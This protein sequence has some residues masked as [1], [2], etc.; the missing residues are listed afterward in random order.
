MTARLDL[1][2]AVEGGAD[3]E[4]VLDPDLAATVLADQ[5]F[6]QLLSFGFSAEQASNVL[7]LKNWGFATE[8]CAQAVRTCNT[9]EDALQSLVRDAYAGCRFSSRFGHH[10]FGISILILQT[11]K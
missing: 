11:G 1:E 6:A 7:Q 2:D 4:Q 9:Y 3:G 5:E 10:R 8:L